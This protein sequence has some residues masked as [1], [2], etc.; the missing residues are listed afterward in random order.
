MLAGGPTAKGTGLGV[1]AGK[2]DPVRFDSSLT[3]CSSMEGAAQVGSARQL[4]ALIMA[5]AAISTVGS[6]FWMRLRAATR[7]LAMKYHYLHSRFTNRM[8]RV[9]QPPAPLGA[10]PRGKSLALCLAASPLRVPSTV[11]GPRAR[12]RPRCFVRRSFGTLLRWGVWL[13]RHTCYR[14]TQVSRS[15]AQAGQK[16]LTEEQVKDTADAVTFNKS[17]QCASVALPSFGQ[18]R[19]FRILKPEVSDKLPQG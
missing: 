16:P 2:E 10:R 9:Q 13:G 12:V 6:S 1:P 18:A 3:E 4:M 8:I 17:P 15:T 11:P 5:F 14:T 19:E 7:K